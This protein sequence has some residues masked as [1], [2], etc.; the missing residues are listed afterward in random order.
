VAGV[1][2]A[3]DVGIGVVVILMEGVSEAEAVGVDGVGT[4]VPLSVVEGE[5]EGVNVPDPTS[6]LG[7]GD[8]SS[9][10]AVPTGVLKLHGAPLSS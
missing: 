1:S 6:I 9:E 10:D 3:E 4:T 7:I 8:I 2:E 5:A